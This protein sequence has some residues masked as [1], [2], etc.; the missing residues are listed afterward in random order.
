M[1]VCFLYERFLVEVEAFQS[2]LTIFLREREKE[3][4]QINQSERWSSKESPSHYELLTPAIVNSE[5]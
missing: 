2:D 4:T 1:A 3:D 5:P